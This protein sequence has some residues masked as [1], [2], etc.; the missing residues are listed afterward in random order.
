MND[1]YKF[2]NDYIDKGLSEGRLRQAHTVPVYLSRNGTEIIGYELRG[3]GYR[4]R[5]IRVHV[6]ER[7]GYRYINY[8]GRKRS[9][10]ML[11]MEAWGRD[12]QMVDIGRPFLRDEWNR[13][14]AEY[15]ARKKG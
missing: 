2:W 10:Q 12:Y 5:F 3:N 4:F 8:S 15:K 9:L 13:Y 11:L 7:T 14:Q 1:G 6:D